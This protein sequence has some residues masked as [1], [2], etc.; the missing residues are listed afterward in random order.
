MDSAD[1]AFGVAAMVKAHTAAHIE[2]RISY[3][4][5]KAAGFAP[6]GSEDRRCR[7]TDTVA[8]S[9]AVGCAWSQVTKSIG[10]LNAVLPASDGQ[11]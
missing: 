10:Q 9:M 7:K 11:S 1:A 2:M 5:P 8:R 4:S 3:T 6:F